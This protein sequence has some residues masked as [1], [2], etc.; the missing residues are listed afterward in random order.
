[1]W[2][3]VVVC[4][5]R[6]GCG[7]VANGCMVSVC[8][9]F[10]LVVGGCWCCRLVLCGVLTVVLLSVVCCFAVVQCGLLVGDGR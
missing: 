2:L 4:G 1:M 9:S 8:V 10:V 6:F 7:M 5:A 3:C